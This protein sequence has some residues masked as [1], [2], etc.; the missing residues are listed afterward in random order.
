MVDELA[1][2]WLASEMSEMQ[3]HEPKAKEAIVAMQETHP[4]VFWNI[5][6]KRI[7][8]AFGDERKA[9]PRE[10]AGLKAVEEA[11]KNPTATPPGGSGRAMSPTEKARLGL[12]PSEELPSDYATEKLEDKQRVQEGRKANSPQAKKQINLNRIIG[13]KR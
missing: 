6:A 1:W 12:S 7:S 10:D 5:Y 8:L 2:I 13:I 3:G 4:E 9:R 11:S